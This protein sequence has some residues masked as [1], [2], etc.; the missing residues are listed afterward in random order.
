MQ[1]LVEICWRHSLMGRTGQ[2]GGDQVL[3]TQRKGSAKTRTSQ[4]CQ[5]V[6]N[7]SPTLSPSLLLSISPPL[8]HSL[9]PPSLSSPLP[10]PCFNLHSVPLTTSPSSLYTPG[11]QEEA[12]C[13]GGRWK[14]T[15]SLPCGC[16]PCSRLPVLFSGWVDTQRN[17]T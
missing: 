9:P 8:P 6:L 11:T 13:W 10:P 17:P 5:P 14:L 1:P 16:S 4:L 2:H 12:R 15:Y 3:V 7:I